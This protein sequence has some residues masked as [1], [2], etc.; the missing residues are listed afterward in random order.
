MEARPV[1][2]LVDIAIVDVV[3]FESGTAA[4]RIWY[5]LE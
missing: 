5:C 4:L 1:E 3:E 2:H